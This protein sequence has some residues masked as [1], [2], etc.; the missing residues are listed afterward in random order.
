[1]RPGARALWLA[2]VLAVAD[3]ASAG[4]VR[5]RQVALRVRF[6]EVARDE[7]RDLGLDW[8]GP[9]AQPIDP[10]KLPVLGSLL[11]EAPTGGDVLATR[12][13]TARTGAPAEIEVGD[14][15]RVA[16]KLRVVPGITSEGN[17]ALRLEVQVAQPGLSQLLDATVVVP[18]G[19]S[20]AI[21][22]LFTDDTRAAARSAPGL[23]DVPVL[24]ALF[25]D[26]S[27]PGGKRDLL[28]LIT[29]SVVGEDGSLRGGAPPTQVVQ[30]RPDPE[31]RGPT[32]PQAPHPPKP[33]YG[34]P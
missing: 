22:G 25:G 24:G 33:G 28:V 11:G 10:A 15:L 31:L 27:F 6:A 19:G 23:G 21:G 7:V 4:D 17:V 29:P 13:A 18:K 3:L 12:Q 20:V 1:V 16:V 32:V 2:L 8:K 34:A 30:P 26:A 14:P 5:P 9:A